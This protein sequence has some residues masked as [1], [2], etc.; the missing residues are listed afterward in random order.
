M[1]HQPALLRSFGWRAMKRFL[2][3]TGRGTP[4]TGCH[5]FVMTKEQVREILDHARDA[6]HIGLVGGRD[7][8][9]RRL[10]LS[11]LI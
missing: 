4:P 6:S 7:G 11:R 2:P 8:R 10:R 1:A 9:Q 3:K 5:I